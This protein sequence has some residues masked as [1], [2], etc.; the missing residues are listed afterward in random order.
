LPVVER[1]LV[2]ADVRAKQE[3]VAALL[4]PDA[5]DTGDTRFVGS[6][7]LLQLRSGVAVTAPVPVDRL[8]ADVAD[9]NQVLK[10]VQSLR[11]DATIAARTSGADNAAG[12]CS[13]DDRVAGPLGCLETGERLAA[14][15]QG[16][17]R[18]SGKS[19][20]FTLRARRNFAVA[21]AL[22]FRAQ[23]ALTDYKDKIP[24][25]LASDI[26]SRIDAVKKALEGTDIDHIKQASDELNTF[27]QKIGEA[28]QGAQQQQGPAAGPS[29]SQAK[30]DI[31]EA[32]VE[33]VDDDKK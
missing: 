4:R 13:G 32:E 18:M 21:L 14:G 9:E 6:L 26:Q 11:I 24:A 27:M 23:K 31:E 10:R 12:V 1:P 15:V 8:V 17:P 16:E 2:V 20:L 33:I 5:G 30:P 25:D 3:N 29:A 22:A 7:P 28:M 19:V